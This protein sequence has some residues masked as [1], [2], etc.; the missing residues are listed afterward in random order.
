MRHPLS[1]KRILFVLCGFD[2]GGAERQALYLAKHLKG[3]GCNV[4]VWGHHH[5][6][7]GPELVISQCEEADI[8]WAEYKFRWPCGKKDLVRDLSRLLWGLHHERPEVIIPYLPWPSV[9]CGLIWR[10]SPAKACIWGQRNTGDLR[11]D[12]LEKTAY[13]QASAIICNASH[14]VDYLKKVMGSTKAPVLVVHNGVKLDPPG[15]SY[16]Q[17]R[18]KLKIDSDAVAVTMVA[19]FR[20]QKDHKILLHAWKK[21]ISD[22]WIFK[23]KPVLVLAGAPQESY[24]AVHKIAADLELGNSIRFPGQIKD[25]SGILGASDIGVLTTKK[26][27]LPNAILEYMICGLPVVATDVSGNREVLG[28]RN[29][30]QLCPKNDPESLAEKIRTLTISPDLRQRLGVRNRYRAIRKFSIE[31]M[32][33]SMTDVIVSEL[34][35]SS[36]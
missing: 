8:R 15:S 33:K 16:S 21:L 10:L 36:R 30:E 5:R 23:Y 18:Q 2:L 32:C 7:R 3:L 29:D 13:R 9:G 28:D 25:I 26:E 35:R 12:R 14:E 22:S 31:A 17:W 24:D 19:N 34:N 1:G 4:C 11:G 20:P 27:G 6:Y